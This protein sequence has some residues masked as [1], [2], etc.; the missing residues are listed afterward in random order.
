V[1]TK[2]KKALVFSML[3]AVLLTA[4]AY[5][6]G[7]TV[8]GQA[9]TFDQPPIMSNGRVLVPLRGVFEHLGATVRWD[10]ANRSV[11][12]TNGQHN[13]AL[14]LGSTAATVDNQ[15]RTLDSPPV[16]V[17]S[18]VLVPLRFVSEALGAEVHWD[19]AAQ[20]VSI[21]SS[22]GVT[23]NVP[24]PLPPAQTV[25][26][27]A[28]SSVEVRS[29]GPVSAGHPVLVV[30]RATP[31]GHA[32]FDIGLHRGI[33]MQEE[34][35]GI[36]RGSYTVSI[37]DNSPNTIVTGH[38]RMP[39]GQQAT[40][41]AS[42]RVILVGNGTPVG[43]PAN[44]IGSVTHDANRPL[45]VG[46]TQTVRL[47]GSPGGR[48]TF[49]VGSHRGLAMQEVSRGTYIGTFT[50]GLGDAEPNARVIGHLTMP[51]GHTASLQAPAG[52]ALV[53]VP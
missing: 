22:G 42:T 39:G 50:A 4:Q 31:R 48:A 9:V 16:L 46:Q 36:Y 7:V 23:T 27:A 13:I 43:Q 8:N 47:Q 30:M 14:Q 49:D 34:S 38:L 51:D 12:A 44:L 3:C 21:N 11:T 52:V 33:A 29:P 45:K 1:N 35:A 2:L 25:S 20:M 37:Y 32:T 5:G 15:T 18:R 19:E 26:P 40:L 6:V 41:N 10:P 24:P 17:G 53:G 28:I